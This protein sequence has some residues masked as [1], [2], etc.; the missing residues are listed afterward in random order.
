MTTATDIEIVIHG[1]VGGRS[2]CG[3]VQCACCADKGAAEPDECGGWS[4]R[5]VAL[6]THQRFTP[7][8]MF[9]FRCFICWCRRTVDCCCLLLLLV[10]PTVATNSLLWLTFK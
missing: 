4:G 2:V 1:G 5:R 10:D 8:S 6:R 3:A 9:V 7:V